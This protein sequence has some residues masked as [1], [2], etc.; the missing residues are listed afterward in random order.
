MPREA[1][2]HLAVHLTLH[3]RYRGRFCY[4]GS[5]DAVGVVV[6]IV[7]RRHYRLLPNRRLLRGCLD[8]SG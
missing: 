4:L 8:A 5:A 7:G 6:Y 1:Q 3:R 2:H